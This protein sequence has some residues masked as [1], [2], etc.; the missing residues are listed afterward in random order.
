[1][2]VIGCK[3]PSSTSTD[4]SSAGTSTSSSSSTAGGG[5]SNRASS[6]GLAGNVLTY[7]NVAVEV[8]WDVSDPVM[9]IKL[10]QEEAASGAGLKLTDGKSTLNIA[11]DG[12]SLQLN[13]R[14]Y[15]PLKERDHV[16]LTKEGKL[17]IN[18]TER[19]PS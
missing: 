2:F 8:P 7:Q 10:S 13:G 1:M 16:V 18:G 6:I 3:K 19:L 5:T 12:R 11:P 15:G 4:G 9:L 14:A 17:M